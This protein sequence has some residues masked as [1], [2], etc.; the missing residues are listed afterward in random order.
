MA[1]QMLIVSKEAARETFSSVMKQQGTKGLATP[2]ER[3]RAGAGVELAAP[4]DLVSKLK[5]P[6]VDAVAGAV[7]PPKL[8]PAQERSYNFGQQSEV[9]RT[10]TK[11]LADH[12]CYTLGGA[13]FTCT[14]PSV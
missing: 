5:P 11:F 4:A 13:P 10:H 14:R 1:D 12:E 6:P 3:D 7:L 2:V 8:K 9:L